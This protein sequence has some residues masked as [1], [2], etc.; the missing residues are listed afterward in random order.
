[1]AGHSDAGNTPDPRPDGYMMIFDERGRRIKKRRYNR[2]ASPRKII[3]PIYQTPVVQHHGRPPFGETV[4][5]SYLS[6]AAIEYGK[7]IDAYCLRHDLKR[8]TDIELF[9]IAQK[10]GYAKKGAAVK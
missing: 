3:I 10:L 5:G 4:H 8:P 1:M 2:I 7:A 6:A 9:R